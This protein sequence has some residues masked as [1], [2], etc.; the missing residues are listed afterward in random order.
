MALPSTLRRF[1]VDVSDVERGVYE[2][3]DLR[4]AQHPSETLRYMLTRILAYALEQREGLEMSRGLCV[5]DEPALSA[6]DLTGRLTA[7][8]EVGSPAADRLHKASKAAPEVVVYTYKAPDSLA[9]DV[10]SRGVHEAEAIA[11]YA[12]DPEFLDALAGTVDRTNAWSLVRT[13]GEVFV[14]VGDETFTCRLERHALE[15]S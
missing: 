10:A 11:L 8:I 6:R 12:V 9:R 7:W 2:T 14:T 5:P 15:A 3:L 13:G 1:T 4:V